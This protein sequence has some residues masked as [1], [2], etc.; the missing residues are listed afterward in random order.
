MTRD[1][2]KK[3]PELYEKLRKAAHEQVRLLNAKV[4]AEQEA[5]KVEERKLHPAK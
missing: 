2:L 1:D 5:K 4:R 3:N